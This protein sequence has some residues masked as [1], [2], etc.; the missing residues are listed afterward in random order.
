[1]VKLAATI[2]NGVF[3]VIET[4]VAN[5]FEAYL[6]GGC[7]RDGLLGRQTNDWDITTNARPD[8]V[9]CFFDKVVLTG[10][11]HG[12]VTVVLDDGQYEVTT[13]RIDVSYT[14]GRRPDAVE[15][16]LAL[17][18][19]LARRDFTVN[20]IA[21]DPIKFRLSDPFDG[22]SDISVRTIR[23]V[24]IPSHRL[25]EDGLR[26]FRAIRFACTLNFEIE[27]RLAEALATT[28]DSVRKVSVERIYIELRKTLTC[29]QAG[30]GLR[31]LHQTGLLRVGLPFLGR[32]DDSA[33][34]HLATVLDKVDCAW[35]LRLAA[36]LSLSEG[37]PSQLCK[38]FKAPNHVQLAVSKIHIAMNWPLSQKRT[39]I[40]DFLALI[41]REHWRDGFALRTIIQ[42]EEQP[43]VEAV[44]QTIEKG[45]LTELPLYA[46]ELAVSGHQIMK[47]LSIKPSKRIGLIMDELLKAVWI[48]QIANN[49]EDLLLRSVDINTRMDA[50]K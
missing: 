50:T 15:Y 1:M 41:G 6:V 12:T 11:D 3:T 33:V 39:D 29:G 17:G 43:Q 22:R 26:S 44:L 8:Q 40:C 18:D 30:R 46:K 35:H 14:D 10:V 21:Y 32:L 7:V 42:S 38:A 9:Q 36:L 13:Y 2:P 37:K 45:R 31:L 34:S 23:A 5:N 49:T 16:T 48:G 24:G 19:D 28:H 27:E 47:E 20:A 4:L 25:Q